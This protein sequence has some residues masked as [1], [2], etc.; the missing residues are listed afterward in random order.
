MLIFGEYAPLPGSTPK[1]WVLVAAPAA[2]WLL[3]EARRRPST[4]LRILIALP[5]SFAAFAMI[6]GTRLGSPLRPLLPLAY[7]ALTV[8]LCETAPGSPQR[9]RWMDGAAA[10]VFA[11][12][13]TLNIAGQLRESERLAQTRGVGL[14]SD[15][16][17][18][19]G[20]DLAAM[21]PKRSSTFPIGGCGCPWRS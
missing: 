3:A 1:T 13:A 8:A 4:L 18:R 16:I 5:I 9:S 10:L 19:L 11:G 14:Y 7:A 20:A 6:F 2:L 12:L 17:N 15:A 21:N